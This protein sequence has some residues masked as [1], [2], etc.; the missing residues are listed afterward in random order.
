MLATRLADLIMPPSCLACR[1]PLAQH[2]AICA[3]C[4]ADIDFIRPPV[5]DRLGL[6]LPFEFDTTPTSSAPAH[7]P[8]YH[9]ARAVALFSGVMREMILQLKYGDTHNARE[10]F[11][12]WLAAAGAELIEECDVI[13]PVPMHARRL[14]MRRFNQSAI[15]ANE[16]ARISDR[17]A[18]PQLIKRTRATRSQVGLTSAERRRNL[19][20]A[21]TIAPR[22]RKHITGRN[23]LLVDD[24]IT[25]GTTLNTCARALRQAGAARVNA[26]VLAIV[27]P[28]DQPQRR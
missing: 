4:W 22:Q 27:V 5:N 20:G 17:Q 25:T 21:F 19:A 23:I 16:L 26:V 15:L 11:G 18:S 8:A 10:L 13:A 1:A 28:T 9:R 24:V 6:P 12:R 7:R 2:D 3:K 14:L